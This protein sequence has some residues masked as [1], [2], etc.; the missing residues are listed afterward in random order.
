MAFYFVAMSWE[1]TRVVSTTLY[2][3]EFNINAYS[4]CFILWVKKEWYSQDHPLNFQNVDIKVAFPHS[5]LTL[6][7]HHNI[8]PPCELFKNS[9]EAL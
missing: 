3:K 1:N 4:L 6:L 2:V 5:N 7:G 9:Q 8:V